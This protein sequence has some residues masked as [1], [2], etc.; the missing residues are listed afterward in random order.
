[1]L[2]E[3]IKLKDI[4][5][6]NK[7]AK[8]HP[9]EQVQQIME[10]IEEFGFNDPIAVWGKD[11]IIV[12][13]HGRYEA[14]KKLGYKEV[15][16]IRLDHMTDEERKAYTL[17]H[18]Q[19]TM[20][21]GF[22]INILNDE[23]NDILNIDMEQFGFELDLDFGFDEELEKEANKEETQRRVENILN[24]EYSQF[25]GDGKYDIPILE[26][27]YGLPKIDEWI[28]F[29]YVLSDNNPKG[30][31]VHFFIDDYQ[32][33]RLWR[34]PDR[35]VE[36]LKQYVC[37]T[38]PDFSPYGDMPLATQI[39]NIYRKNWVGAYLQSKGVT[40]IPTIRASTDERSLEFY[41]DGMPK[42]SIVMISNMWISDEELRNYFMTE[43]EKMVE[44]LNPSKIFVYGKEMDF[45]ENVEFVKTFADKR[46]ER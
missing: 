34:N 15:D 32:F 6:Y 3:K 25:N 42:N 17:A 26:P 36:K 23:L 12:E 18:N 40:V 22:D 2:V 44:T 9:Q 16:C 39:F 13:G 5:P 37:V 41:L 4:K 38:T 20:N 28:G 11:N 14:C 46:W 45:K 21:S 1:M 19:L 10:S 35:Y 31:A 43:Y 27:V 8:L 33:E 7:N 24:L 29:N 30:K